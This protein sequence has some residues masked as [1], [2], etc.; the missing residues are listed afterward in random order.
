MRLLCGILAGQAFTSVLTGDPQLCRRPMARVAGPLQQMGARVETTDGHAPITLRGEHLHGIDYAL[1]VASAQVKS[2][3]LLAGLYA[4]SPTILREPGPARDHT[5][6][7][8]QLQIAS[9]PMAG[10]K[11]QPEPGTLGPLAYDD[12]TWTLDPASIDHLRPLDVVIPGDFSS[13]SF[14]LVASVLVPGSQVI[15]EGVGVNPTRTGLLDVLR[16]MGAQVEVENEREQGGEPVADLLIRARP[17]RGTLVRGDVVVRMIDEFP[18]LAV[19][20][21][22]AHGQTVV[23]DAAE[24]RV[25]ETDRIASVVAELLKLGA[26][27]EPYRDG[28]C[29]SGPTPLHGDTVDSH[30]DH[31]LAM[32]LAVAGSTAEGQTVVQN[33]DCIADSFPGFAHVLSSLDAYAESPQGA[34]EQ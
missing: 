34:V 6:R 26:E 7:M 27:V 18:V 17:L 23:H 28:F 14:L 3:L 29:V 4:D 22:Q 25:K 9:R 1:P 32:A 16:T 20:A 13:A 31:R 12:G 11:S 30:G 8:L 10:R 19:A 5:E 33:A 21:S 2:A 24:L 15:I